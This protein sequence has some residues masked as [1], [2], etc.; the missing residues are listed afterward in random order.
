MQSASALNKCK[1][2]IDERLALKD[3]MAQ[4]KIR[5]TVWYRPVLLCL[6]KNESEVGKE[7]GHAGLGRFLFARSDAHMILRTFPAGVPAVL[8]CRHNSPSATSCRK[9][10]RR[11]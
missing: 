1:E 11:Y 2:L 10:S 8:V 6:E 4:F 5:Y 7:S 3:E 9:K